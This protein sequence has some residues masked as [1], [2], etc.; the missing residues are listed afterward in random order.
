MTGRTPVP[1]TQCNNYLKWPILKEI[2][3]RE[4]IYYIATGHYVQKHYATDIGI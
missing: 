1:C 4:G 2:A 3:D